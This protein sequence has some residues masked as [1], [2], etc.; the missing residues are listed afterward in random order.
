MNHKNMKVALVAIVVTI[1]IT[2]LASALPQ[3]A[4]AKGHHNHN[5]GGG[6]KV[7]QAV[8]Q[9]NDC[10]NATCLNDANNTASIHK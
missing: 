2:S 5:T 8:N 1:A 9:F 7:N 4:M 10:N 3:Q 6:I